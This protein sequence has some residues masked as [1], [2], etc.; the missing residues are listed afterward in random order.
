M[1]NEETEK[2]EENEQLFK[3]VYCDFKCSYMS[4]WNRH[5]HTRKHLINVNGNNSEIK[6]GEK[7]EIIGIHQCSN[8]NKIY[9]S[10]SGLWK[11]NKKCVNTSSLEQQSEIKILTELVKKYTN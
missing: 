3:C 8:C 5:I 2:N 4:D 1:E 6:L 9:K 11:H 7:N 10:L